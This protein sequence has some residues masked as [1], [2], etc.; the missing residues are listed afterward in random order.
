MR[1]PPEARQVEILCNH[2]AGAAL[3][4]RV[5]LI[6][7]PLVADHPAGPWADREIA[8]LAARYGVSREVVLRRLLVLGKTSEAFYRRRR[9]KLTEEHLKRPQG[10]F[11][12]PHLLAVAQAGPLFT[13]LVLTNYYSDRVTATDVA[14]YLAVNLKH[15]PKIETEVLRG[16]GAQPA[17]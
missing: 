3:I 5:D 4:P 6:S 15:L 11:A 7:L 10:G 13:R 17:R 8:Q 12:P 9:E 14:D 16:P 1:H 2:A